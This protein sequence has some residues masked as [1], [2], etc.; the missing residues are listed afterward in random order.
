[1]PEDETIRQHHQLNGHEFVQTP[2]YSGGQ[3]SLVACNP[4]GYRVRHDL[5]TEQQLKITIKKAVP[6]IIAATTK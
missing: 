2:G 3:R 6:L 4:W 1:M 5:V